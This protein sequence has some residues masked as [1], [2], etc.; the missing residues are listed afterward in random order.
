[1]GTPALPQ[2][3]LWPNYL[4]KYYFQWWMY[5]DRLRK[6]T[7]FVIQ[8]QFIKTTTK[9]DD[10]NIWVCPV[11]FSETHTSKNTHTPQNKAPY[12]MHAVLCKRHGPP[13]IDSISIRASCSF[14][15]LK[16]KKTHLTENYTEASTTKYNMRC[17]SVWSIW[18]LP[19]LQWRLIRICFIEKSAFV[20]C[21]FYRSHS[22]ASCK[23][24]QSSD[25]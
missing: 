16:K 1:M 14:S 20:F 22:C 10:T 4:K 18:S 2:R 19:L 6:E 17:F 25:S 13:S 23:H 9:K 21:F 5:W 3:A 15:S 24:L 7:T 11:P 12:R 8:M